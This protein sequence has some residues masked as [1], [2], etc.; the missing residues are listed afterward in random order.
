MSIIRHSFNLDSLQ[1]GEIPFAYVSACCDGGY[2]SSVEEALMRDLNQVAHLLPEDLRT[3]LRTYADSHEEPES[4]DGL[5]SFDQAIIR[6]VMEYQDTRDPY[7][8]YHLQLD[9]AVL[10]CEGDRRFLIID[11]M[12]GPQINLLAKE[13]SA[14]A[15]RL[16]KE[17]AQARARIAE[18]EKAL[19][20]D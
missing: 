14:R 4:K 1:E 11:P 10:R 15:D 13:E 12:Y 19:S 3:R 20:Q 7:G 17:L 5:V 9:V 8:P 2:A 6:A 18:L 16:E